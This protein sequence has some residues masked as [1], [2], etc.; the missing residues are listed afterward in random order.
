MQESVTLSLTGNTTTL[1]V[2]YFP[3]IDVYDDSEI[4]LLNL[5]TYNTFP[6]INE[7]NN[8]FEIHL[9]NPDRLLNNNKFPTCFITLKKGCY[10]IKDIK[11]QILAQ[12]NNFNND[13]EYL[14]IEKITFDIGI[15]QVDFRTTIFSNGTIC[16]NVENSIAP[17]LGFEK[18]NYEHYIDGHRSQKVSNL[19]IVN[20]IKVMCN[21]AQ[22]SF[23]NHMSSHSIYE[24]SPNNKN[25][26][27]PLYMNNME[28]FSNI[29]CK[30]KQWDINELKKHKK[31]CG[32]H[33]LGRLVM[34]DNGDDDTIY[35]KNFKRSQRIPITLITHKHKL[36][37]Y[38]FYV[39]IDY[40]II[41]KYLIKKYKIPTKL[42]NYRNRNAAK[43]FIKTMIDIDSK[44]CNLYKINIPMDKLTVVRDH[45]HFTGRFRSAVCLNCNFELT[46][47]SFIPIYFHN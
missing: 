23:N 16:F 8:H 31:N 3:P 22:G 21:I 45:N 1:S 12:I 28:I 7:T 43:H 13:L 40:D 41:S 5:Q 30:F 4:A 32:K 34:F 19:N 27:F 14:E 11:N 44:V 42:H 36:M 10:D 6:N 38:A 24:F 29:P 15:D 33:K 35:F 18:K 20:S 47:V 25:V 26:V 39:K 17:L 37:S 2:H 9:V 46:N